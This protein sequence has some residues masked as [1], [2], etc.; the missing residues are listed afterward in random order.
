MALVRAGK[1]HFRD[2]VGLTRRIFAVPVLVRP[3]PSIAPN[4]LA[5]RL[6][7]RQEVRTARP[8]GAIARFIDDDDRGVEAVE[9]V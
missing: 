3:L 6:Q 5:P 9:A 7:N 1:H 2:P 8:D 4:L